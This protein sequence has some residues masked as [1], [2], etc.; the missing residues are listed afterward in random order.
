MGVGVGFVEAYVGDWGVGLGFEGARAAKAE[1]G[2]I[3]VMMIQVAGSGAA[4][5]REASWKG[6]SQTRWRGRSLSKLKSSP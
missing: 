1:D 6:S 2:P 3:L 4:T 5:R